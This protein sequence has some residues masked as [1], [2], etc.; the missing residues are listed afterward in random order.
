MTPQ[1]QKIQELEQ[2]MT[3]IA[4]NYGT[5]LHE[6]ILRAEKDTTDEFAFVRWALHTIAQLRRLAN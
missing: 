4:T 6:L 5:T 1:E 3:I 2:R